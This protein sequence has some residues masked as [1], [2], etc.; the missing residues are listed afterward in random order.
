MRSASRIARR[1]VVLA[2][3]GMIALPLAVMSVFSLPS[4][5][6]SPGPNTRVTVTGSFNVKAI[7]GVV[8][9]GAT[10]PYTLDSLSFILKAK[11]LTKLESSALQP[12]TKDITASH[13]ANEY[14]QSPTYVSQ[15][16]SYLSSFG[17]SDF[18]LYADGVDL[19]AIGTTTEVN[20]AFGTQEENYT[21]P[22]SASVT[23]HSQQVHAPKSSAG[24]PARLART[25][26]AVLGLTS[27]EPWVSQATHTTSK[28]KVESSSATGTTC[29][30][31]G[32]SA[33][34][35]ACH[36]P[37]DF[38][39]EYGLTGLYSRGFEG[40]GETI[41]IVT[42]AGL[43]TTAPPVFWK[44]VLGM[45]PSGRTLTVVTVDGGP[46][47]PST[48]SG[49]GETDLDTEQ[50]GALAPDANIV[51]YQ[52]PN[53]TTTGAF[54]DDWFTAAS[55]DVADTVSC[56]WGESETIAQLFGAEGVISPGLL[57]SFTEAF[58]EM[59]VQGQSVFIA[60]GDAG[61]YAAHR[62]TGG[63]FKNLSVGIPSSDPL[64]TAAGG[65]TTPWAA[66]LVFPTNGT[67][68]VPVD[69][70]S[71]RAWGWDY[72]MKAVATGLTVPFQTVA[73][74]AGVIAGGT[75]GYSTFFSM[76]DYQKGVSGTGQFSAVQYFTP[77]NFV[78][79]L[80]LSIP[81]TWIA[82]EN[83]SV[84]HGTGTGRAV[85]DVSADADPYSG[86]LLYNTSAS[87]GRFLQGGWGGTSFVAPQ[88]NG[89][90]AVIDSALGHR[91]GFWNPQIYPMASGSS[92]PFTPLNSQGQTNDNLYYTGTPGTAYNPATGL[93]TPTFSA[94]EAAFA[95]RK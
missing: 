61:A 55:Q 22:A 51:V 59:A 81:F 19:K 73:D 6:A 36:T 3:A 72:L 60:S 50:S 95:G 82:T 43:D 85:P 69:V 33:P 42:L 48:G 65:T 76:P 49:T 54:L 14:G 77:T 94:L 52:A 12:T 88:L 74:T 35:A 56:S 80:G 9:T 20:Q 53:S 68:H 47:A 46:G 21:V 28:A 8:A 27:Y 30:P 75:G 25:V 40:Q 2:A 1:G 44:T 89:A 83:P 45:T 78:T 71:Q 37:G 93:G 70:T 92:S 86:Y 64:A 10:T 15:L 84:S 11:N 17:I 18:T 91:A 58:A 16:E 26:L 67:K 29:A 62:T 87:T 41:G 39:K 23:G 4:T 24:L 34:P 66:T 7:P 32:V 90:T 63:L 79:L 38:A 57:A 31:F 5:G 13:F